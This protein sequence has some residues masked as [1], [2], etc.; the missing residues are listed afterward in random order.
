M[1][2]LPHCCP[3]GNRAYGEMYVCVLV[4][5]HFCPGGDGNV[6]VAHRELLDEP[7]E[8]ASPDRPVVQEMSVPDTHSASV[9][10]A[11]AWVRFSQV[12]FRHGNCPRKRGFQWKQ[13]KI[14]GKK[15]AGPRKKC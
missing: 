6:P 11:R 7:T 4:L 13:K 12:V 1:L 2:V 8:Q 15:F 9:R 10:V 5:P 14:H 3:V